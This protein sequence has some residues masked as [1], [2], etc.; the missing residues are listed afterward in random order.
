[1]D[2]RYGRR[3]VLRDGYAH[4]PMS[5]LRTTLGGALSAPARTRP[6]TACRGPYCTAYLESE[7]LAGCRTRRVLLSLMSRKNS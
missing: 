7:T 5:I 6:P 2:A 3:W 1:M 4:P